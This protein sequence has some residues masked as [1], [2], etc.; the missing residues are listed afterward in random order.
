MK[1]SFFLSTQIQY[2]DPSLP[3]ATNWAMA[4]FPEGRPCIHPSR[5]LLES[6]P[7]ITT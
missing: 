1:L 3:M 7:Q 6:L 2:G 5:Y 4:F